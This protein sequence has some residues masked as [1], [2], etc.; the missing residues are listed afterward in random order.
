M[1]DML[2]SVGFREVFLPALIARRDKTLRMLATTH[3]ELDVMRQLQG[4]FKILNAMI[5]NPKAF[6]LGRER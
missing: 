1:L 3:A 2:G 6:I 4:E 5:D